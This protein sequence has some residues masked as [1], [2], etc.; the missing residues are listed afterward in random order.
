M[1]NLNIGQYKTFEL[2]INKDEYWDFYLHRSSESVYD[3]CT[4]GSVLY[5]KSLIANID[6]TNPEC[7]QNG[8]LIG[9]D[10]YV[11]EDAVNVNGILYN[12]GYTGLDNGL[13]PFRRDTITNKDFL[14][15]YTKSEYQIK[16]GFTLG[17]HQVSG[18]T[19]LFE[20]PISINENSVKLNGGFYQGFFKTTCDEYQIL[21]SVIE[22]G[23]EWNLQFTLFKS[24]LEKES[25]KTLNDK[26][27]NNKGIFFY[28]GTRAENKWDC[29]YNTS[30][31]SGEIDECLKFTNINIT[32]EDMSKLDDDIF[33]DDYIDEG[34]N[35]KECPK[36]EDTEYLE[37]DIDLSKVELTTREGFELKESHQYYIDTDNK[38]LLFNRTKDGITVNT[39]E[40]GDHVRYVG[41]KN[42]FKDNLYL[43]MNRT[44]TGFT[45]NNIDEYRDTFV[46]E[47][48]IYK[49]LYSNAI[50]FRITDNGEIGYRYLIEDCDSENNLKIREGYSTPG[51]VK[52]D[53]WVSINIKIIGHE[54]TMVI[55]FYVNGKLVFV[56]D[57]MPKLNLRALDDLYEKQEAVP[58]SISIG[59]GTQG[60]AETILPN[61]MSNPDRVYPLE[62]NFAGSFIGHLKN[63]RFF[64]GYVPFSAIV[65]NSK[66]DLN[67]IYKK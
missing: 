29:L 53:E 19:R 61:Y 47:Y 12:I 11:W 33:G 66:Y 60:L 6:I 59:G 16:D 24:D 26:Y 43:L 18:A 1:G 25:D 50:A 37:D 45:V 42:D 34:V 22:K 15:L 44:K 49:D 48:N 54:T 10:G 7:F 21:P 36:N 27:P 55:Y 56:T 8:M 39:Y 30:E 38:F 65:N 14:Q 3:L 20:Y 13:I 46:K 2:K 62:E 64:K 5:D 51:I 4:D 41:T 9:M 23:E 32:D 58:Y 28:I 57:P 35:E 52:N 67:N 17:L 63:F 40:E 31:G